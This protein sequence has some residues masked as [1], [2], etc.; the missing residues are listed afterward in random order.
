MERE[1]SPEGLSSWC[2][3]QRALGCL[4]NHDIC[5][6][7]YLDACDCR[8]DIYIAYA[9]TEVERPPW[10]QAGRKGNRVGVGTAGPCPGGGEVCAMRV[11]CLLGVSRRGLN[12]AAIT[13]SCSPGT[14]MSTSLLTVR[15][16]VSPARGGHSL[17]HW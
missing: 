14:R 7:V 11:L 2:C 12:C 15:R 17:E 5:P 10:P 16:L 9:V 1:R 8:R 4:G 13:R 3:S 6:F